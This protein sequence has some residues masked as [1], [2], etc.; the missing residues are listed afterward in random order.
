MIIPEVVQATPQ[1]NYIVEVLFRDGKVV[2]FDVK[3]LLNKGVFS[4]LKD[5][6]FFKNR[7]TVMNHTL[8]WDISGE[9]D[10]TRCIDID[11]EV[12]YSIQ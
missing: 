3:P 11:P 5:E 2:Y 1:D 12:L 6:S 7:C 10:S 9:Y 8:A 4:L